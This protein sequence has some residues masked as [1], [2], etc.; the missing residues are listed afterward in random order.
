MENLLPDS[1]PLYELST[2]VSKQDRGVPSSARLRRALIGRL[3]TDFTELVRG[4]EV[5]GQIVR[6]LQ[7]TSSRAVV[8]GG[9]V[10]DRLISLHCGRSILPRDIDLVVHGLDAR[11]L[12]QLL[13]ANSRENIFGGLNVPTAT[14]QLDIWPL[15]RTHMI[16]RRRLPIQFD[17]LPR[18]TVFRINSIV[19]YPKELFADPEL[20]DAGCFDAIAT[21]VVDFQSRE[22]P[23][24]LVQVARALM[25]ATKL[26]FDLADEVA[27]FIRQVCVGPDELRTV[28]VGLRD[29]CP[30]EFVS[31][32]R[33]L[34]DAVLAPDRN[35]VAATRP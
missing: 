20:S 25:Y 31:G 33:A 24:P 11:Q 35:P 10:R 29:Y 32:A 16:V 13:P 18:T 12:R 23:L 30:K 9:W 28:E 4:D 1:I 22:V 26:Q 3:Q 17:T 7:S 15:D 27:A 19:F 34:L 2:F 14:T 6:R 8:F 21:R 5:L